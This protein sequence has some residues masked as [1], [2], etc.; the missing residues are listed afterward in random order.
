[1][2]KEIKVITG[3]DQKKNKHLKQLEDS[4]RVEESE[5]LAGMKGNKKGDISE[6]VFSDRNRSAFIKRSIT[7]KGDWK[8]ATTSDSRSPS[9]DGERP[10]KNQILFSQK[11]LDDYPLEIVNLKEI[12][13]QANK[14]GISKKQLAKVKMNYEFNFTNSCNLIQY[15][16]GYISPLVGNVWFKVR[17]PELTAEETLQDANINEEKEYSSTNPV[18]SPLFEGNVRSFSTPSG[19][20]TSS[21]DI[22]IPHFIPPVILPPHL[23]PLT[24]I[25][26]MRLATLI[27]YSLINQQLPQY[28]IHTSLA[29]ASEYYHSVKEFVMLMIR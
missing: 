21:S 18:V 8:K 17:K 16:N 20:C 19:S 15:D 26:R 10:Q 22:R 9:T 28:S 23:Q 7:E 25:E 5:P 27:K 6:S 4:G 1:M 13:N 24:R 12:E 11:E 14:S 3:A 29:H 2:K